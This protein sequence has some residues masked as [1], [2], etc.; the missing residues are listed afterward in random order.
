[1]EKSTASFAVRAFL[2]GL[3]VAGS[4]TTAAAAPESATA[5][6][7]QFPTNELMRHFRSLEDPQLSPDGTHALL[8]VKDAA[9]D[10][11]K[12]HIWLL[13]VHGGE[14]RQLTYSPESDKQGEHSPR[15]A[16]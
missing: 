3:A 9:A 6:Q 5:S 10:G 15:W 7:K 4:A 13:D 8:Q 12:S 11:G 16:P 1:M 14:P 2:F